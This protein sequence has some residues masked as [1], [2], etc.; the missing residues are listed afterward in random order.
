MRKLLLILLFSLSGMTMFAQKGVNGIGINLDWYYNGNARSQN[1]GLDIKYQ[2]NI[3]NHG[4]IETFVSYTLLSS[5]KASKY[6]DKETDFIIGINYH[7]FLNKVTSTRPYILVGAAYGHVL[8]L[9]NY[10]YESPDLSHDSYPYYGNPGVNHYDKINNDAPIFRV[11]VGIDHRISQSLS[12]QAE[13]AGTVVV[14]FSGTPKKA[15]FAPQLKI[16]IAY[17]F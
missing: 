10:W 11:G 8:S 6:E 2:Y 7:Q 17:N 3:T 12:F 1:F 14:N 16:G 15:F 4:R 13:L 9:E 5:F